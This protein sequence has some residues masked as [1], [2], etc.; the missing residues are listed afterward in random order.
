VL[1]STHTWN[2]DGSANL[3]VHVPSHSS[4][5]SSLV[6]SDFK[7]AAVRGD[8]KLQSVSGDPSAEFDVQT[9]SGSI[10]NC[11]GPKPTESKH[12]S[13]SRLTFTNGAGGAHVHIATQSGDLRLCT[14]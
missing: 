2:T 3:V 4:V 6:S 11:F 7:I 14:R 5:S 12:G 13:G 8:L 1:H 9:V 10:D